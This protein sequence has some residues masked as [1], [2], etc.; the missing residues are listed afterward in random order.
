MFLLVFSIIGFTRI[1]FIIPNKLQA[2]DIMDQICG[3]MDTKL[4][5]NAE[6]EKGYIPN[7]F[8]F[9]G[10]IEFKNVYFAYPTN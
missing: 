10:R 1:S 9:V 8:S 2:Y 4:V 3:I 7:A 5:L 6:S